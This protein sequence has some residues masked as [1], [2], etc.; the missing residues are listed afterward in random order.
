VEQIQGV[1]QLKREY[2]A[3]CASGMRLH[4]RAAG[5]QNIHELMA[6]ILQIA[7]D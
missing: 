7:F 1:N 4:I 6:R 3:P 2:E 5:A